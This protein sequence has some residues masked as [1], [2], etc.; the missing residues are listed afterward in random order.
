MYYSNKF[1]SWLYLILNMLGTCK[2]CEDSQ[3][4]L[5][6]LA[7]YCCFDC[8]IMPPW[9]CIYLFKNELLAQPKK[10]PETN[11]IYKIQCTCINNYCGFLEV[12]T[13][14]NTCISPQKT[15]NTEPFQ[16]KV[17][18]N[19]GIVNFTSIRGYVIMFQTKGIS[20]VH[21]YII[22]TATDYCC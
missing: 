15:V 17:F 4:P 2:R 5:L 14:Q 21:V 22:I 11:R 3:L 12:L 7:G 16:C 20:S 18:I 19:G 1:G 10:T 8:L 13:S 9:F 6:K